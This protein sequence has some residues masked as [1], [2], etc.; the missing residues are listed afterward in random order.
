MVI[1]DLDT[2]CN[3]KILDLE[4]PDKYLNVN[5]NIH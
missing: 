5:L 2:F 3:S 4:I 1:K